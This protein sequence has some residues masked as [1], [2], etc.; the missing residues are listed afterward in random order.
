[1]WNSLRRPICGLALG[2]L[3]ALTAVPALAGGVKW[4]IGVRAPWPVY[5][6][7]P[8]VYLPPPPVYV[9][10][11]EYLPAPVYMPRRVIYT[12]PPVWVGPSRVVYR[13][14]PQTWHVPQPQRGPQNWH[15]PQP[16]RGP[17]N[18]HDP[19]PGH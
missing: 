3:A 12:R 2:A 8:V 18:W 14:G 6:P 10:A 13:H 15:D 5:L 1:M 7:A 4:S 9:P 17:Q 16:Q 19:R 11:V